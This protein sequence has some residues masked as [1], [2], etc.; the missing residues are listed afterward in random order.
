MEKIEVP[1]LVKNQFEEE[2]RKFC[3]WAGTDMTKTD[4]V[5]YMV[6]QS[7]NNRTNRRLMRVL[8]SISPEKIGI[9]GRENKEK[10]MV[11]RVNDYLFCEKDHNLECDHCIFCLLSDKDVKKSLHPKY[12]WYVTRAFKPKIQW[13]KITGQKLDF[14]KIID[15]K[16]FLDDLPVGDFKAVEIDGEIDDSQR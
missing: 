5:E 6:L 1:E 14:E 7:K 9:L 12:V 3:K 8:F 4:F 10:V 16:T 15:S 11:Q 2:Y 13:P